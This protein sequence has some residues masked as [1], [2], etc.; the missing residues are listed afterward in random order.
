MTAPPRRRPAARPESSAPPSPESWRSRSMQRWS[1]LF[2]MPGTRA[3]CGELGRYQAL[4]V[5]AA[6]GG[7]AGQDGAAVASA[8]A[9]Q[10]RN[11]VDTCLAATTTR[12][13]P[14][15]A[16]GAALLVLLGSWW[17]GRARARS[18]PGVAPAPGGVQP[19]GDGPRR[20]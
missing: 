17:L 4:S 7:L 20:R 15:Y 2:P 11:A 5:Q 14:V 19:G 13:R 10:A 12:W 8:Q 16:L 9:D 6:V 1:W 3:A 18:H